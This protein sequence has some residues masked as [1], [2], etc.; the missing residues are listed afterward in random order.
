MNDPDFNA[1][2]LFADICE[3]VRMYEEVG[4][5]RG[6]EIAEQSMENMIQITGVSGGRVIRT[7]GDG[8]KSVYSG[9][10][11]AYDA[12]IKMQLSHQGLPCAIKV[13]FSYGTIVNA[14]DDVFGDTV[15]LGA[16]LLGIARPGEILMPGS[17]AAQLSD[18]RRSNTRMLDTR[19]LRGRSEPVEVFFTVVHCEQA[20]ESTHTV[21]TMSAMGHLLA[22]PSVL[23]LAHAGSEHRHTSTA[24]PLTIGRS[25]A[26]TLV[27]NNDY[28]WRLH[29]QI[30][31]VGN[32]FLLTDLSTNGT[33]VS[34]NG[35]QPVFIKRES[36]K[37][38]GVGSS[39]SA[40][41]RGTVRMTSSVSVTTWADRLRHAR[42]VVTGT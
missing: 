5:Q 1:A 27:V 15:H 37:L 12:A 21:M 22:R 20:E 26:C 8:V 16:R 14:Q 30:E 13:A 18:E 11:V 9:V 23:V 36:V 28:A 32:A 3:S 34:A 42:G 24:Q 7:Q 6:I 17:T 33:Y 19:Y 4:N 40:S 31:F 41:R 10:D 39:R 35:N 2:V 29:A 25:D 38:N